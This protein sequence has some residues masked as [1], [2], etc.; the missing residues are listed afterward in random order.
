[1][2]KWVATTRSFF[3]SLSVNVL[4]F[5][6]AKTWGGLRSKATP[7]KFAESTLATL[8]QG[9]F[10]NRLSKLHFRLFQHKIGCLTFHSD[11]SNKNDG[12][13]EP[14]NAVGIFKCIFPGCSKSL[15]SR[16]GLRTHMDAQSVRSGKAESSRFYAD[17]PLPY[18]QL[19]GP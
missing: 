2:H 19:G 1:M 13:L 12:T 15:T 9:C 10:T 16:S 4:L 7:A 17:V 8:R 11:S 3:Y 6:G 5:I 14:K 18:R